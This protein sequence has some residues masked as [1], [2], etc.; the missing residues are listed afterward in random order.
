WK[1]YQTVV[2]YGWLRRSEGSP[3]L[4]PLAIATEAEYNKKLYWC[5]GQFTNYMVFSSQAKITSN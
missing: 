5:R 4:A 2:T 1:D 3:R